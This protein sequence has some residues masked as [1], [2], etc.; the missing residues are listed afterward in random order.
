MFVLGI[1][2][3]TLRFTD[4]M[5]LPG[6]LTGV[7]RVTGNDRKPLDLFQGMGLAGLP[8]AVAASC[9][10][11][12]MAAALLVGIFGA[13]H[14]Q[15][16]SK[17]LLAAWWSLATLELVVR[18]ALIVFGEKLG[19]NALV[20]AAGGRVVDD[21]CWGMPLGAAWLGLLGAWL[22]VAPKVVGYNHAKTPASRTRSIVEPLPA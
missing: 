9:L 12:A 6:M 13:W 2:A 14:H 8:P 7:L 16:W 22:L 20:F 19:M 21:A 5:I 15:K 11:F 3:A 10:N 18:P 1:Y 4:A 17:F